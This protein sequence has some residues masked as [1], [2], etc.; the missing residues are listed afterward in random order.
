MIPGSRNPKGILTNILDL[1]S[2][3]ALSLLRAFMGLKGAN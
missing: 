1:A 2:I 3:A